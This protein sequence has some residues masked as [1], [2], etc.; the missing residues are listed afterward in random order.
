MRVA[1]LAAAL[2]L[3]LALASIGNAAT[4]EIFVRPEGDAV[5]GAGTLWIRFPL[6]STRP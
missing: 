6:V 2:A 4:M 5:G 1:R 3:V